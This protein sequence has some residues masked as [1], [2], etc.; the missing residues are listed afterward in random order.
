MSIVADPVERLI[1]DAVLYRL[2][3]PELRRALSGAKSQDKEASRLAEDLG[4]ARGRLDELAQMF[5]AGEITRREWLTA[6]K[7]IEAS[8]EQAAR[9]MDHQAGTGQLRALAGQGESLRVQWDTL[10]LNR[11]HAIVAALLDHAVI[12]P[13][14]TGAQSVDLARVQPVWRL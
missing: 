1:A 4:R 8:I 10:N 5:G 11:Q 12:G 9:K 6:R 7:P 2:D 13:G 14:K 3:T